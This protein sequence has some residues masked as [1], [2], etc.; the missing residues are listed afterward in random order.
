MEFVELVYLATCPKKGQDRGGQSHFRG[1][2]SKLEE[3]RGL[4]VGETKFIQFN[5]I[6]KEKKE[7]W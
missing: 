7:M 2:F 4:G 3:S 1:V 6:R 5:G